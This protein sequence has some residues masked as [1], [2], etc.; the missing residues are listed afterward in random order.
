[1]RNAAHNL[2][3]ALR[4]LSLFTW[5]FG[6]LV[7]RLLRLVTGVEYRKAAR[8][9]EA[10]KKLVLC[11]ARTQPGSTDFTGYE[12]M[13]ISTYRVCDTQRNSLGTMKFW[14]SQNEGVYYRDF[15]F[16]NPQMVR[17]LGLRNLPLQPVKLSKGDAMAAL[18]EDT[19]REIESLLMARVNRPHGV[20]TFVEDPATEQPPQA[21]AYAAQESKRRSPAPEP[22]QDAAIKT[23]TESVQHEPRSQSAAT[24]SR[25]TGAKV[26]SQYEGVFLASGIGRR[27]IKNNSTKGPEYIDVEQFYIDIRLIATEAKGAVHRVWGADLERALSASQAQPDDLIRVLHKGRTEVVNMDDGVKGFKNLYEVVRIGGKRK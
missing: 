11:P 18:K 16:V 22:V 26:H 21:K 12:P 10:E 15:T 27:S 17:R 25:A 8:E 24:A 20:A 14:Y 23:P 2:L 3:L 4:H 7:F 19:L 5:D 6:S 13:T 1:M 9:A